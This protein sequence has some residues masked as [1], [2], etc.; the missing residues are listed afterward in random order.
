MADRVISSAIGSTDTRYAVHGPFWTSPSVGYIVVHPSV[1]QVIDVR[2]TTDSGTNWTVQDP[3]FNP[4]TSNIRSQAVWYDRETPGN[5]G[6]LIHVAFVAASGG[7]VKYAVFD[8][9]DDTWDTVRDVDSLTINSTGAASDVGITVSKSGRVYLC[10]RGDFAADTEDTDHSMRSSSD[11]FVSNNESEASPYSADEEQMRLF[12]GTDADEDDIS[13]VVFDGVNQDL[14]FWKF[15]A[16][17]NS[18]STTTI[19]ASILVT[20]AEGRD[21]KS[22]FDAAIRHSDEHILVAY[23]NDRDVSTGDLRTVDITQAT[24]TI[25][26]EGDIHQSDDSFCAG[27]L[28]NQ[29][30][31][32]VYVAYLGSDAGDEILDSNVRCYFKLSVNGMT[33]WGSEQTYGVENVILRMVMTGHTIGDDG[34]RVMPVLFY[35]GG[36]LDMVNDDN[37]I[38]IEAAPSTGDV[39]VGASPAMGPQVVA[40]PTQVSGY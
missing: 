11:L 21:Q 17:A 1:G 40:V 10:A 36:T 24:P 35:S 8:T 6:T 18:W 12:P 23:W 19:D 34:G 3:D 27:I 26:Q 5:T 20:A 31:N 32:D 29:P 14:E 30:N 38:E 2:K 15:D 16:T 9:S 25:T 4:V 13:A 37:D 28:I 33:S 7:G 39:L 22:F